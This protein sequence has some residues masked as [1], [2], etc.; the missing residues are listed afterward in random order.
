[1]Y[2]VYIIEKRHMSEL[3]KRRRLFMEANEGKAMLETLKAGN[4]ILDTSDDMELIEKRLMQL[5]HFRYYSKMYEYIFHEWGT[6]GLEQTYIEVANE[7]LELHVLLNH[8]VFN[9]LLL[10]FLRILAA[11]TGENPVKIHANRMEIMTKLWI[12]A[13]LI[14]D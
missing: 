9:E 11:A 12:D 14:A 5:L 13:G 1:M 8:D 3:E 2:L 10:K 7:A 4:H 6:D